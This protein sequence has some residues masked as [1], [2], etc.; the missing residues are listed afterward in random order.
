MQ[1]DFLNTY[2]PNTL[3]LSNSDVRQVRQQLSNYTELA[4]PDIANNPGTVIGDLI[5]TPQSYII[6]ALQKGMENAFSDLQLEN[7]ANGI[8]YNCDFTKSYIKNFG[9]D[10][11]LYY[12]SSGVLRL[13][14]SEDKDYEL[15]RST[16]FKLGNDIYSIYLPNTGN[17]TCLSTS[18]TPKDGENSSTIKDT[19]SGLWFCDVPVIGKNEQVT[20]AA[21]SQA[22]ISQI[23]PELASVYA[24][25]DFS[26]GVLA[27][28]VQ[29][30]AKKTQTTMFSA[31]LNTRYG[32]IQYLNTVCPFVESA[33]ALRDGDKELLRTYRNS[34]G[35]ASGCLDIFAR[36][37]S[38]E[39]TEVQQ[40]KLYLSEDGQWLE[41][42]W[43]YTGQ[44]Y[45]LESITHPSIDVKDLEDREIIS[46]SDPSLNL[47]AIA[48]Y[49]K[50]EKLTIRLKNLFD[51]SQNSLFSFNIETQGENKGKQYTYVTVT[52]Q[53]DPLFRALASTVEN[54]DYAPINSNV[55]VRGFTPV[56]IS[57]FDVVYT[58]KPGVIPDLD[59]A[60]D[61]IKIY[62]G[63]LG[64]P[65]QFSMAEIASIMG[66]VG[67]NYVKTV[68]VNAKVQWSI[69]DKIQNFQGEIEDTLETI[70]RSA[71]ELRVY[72]PNQDRTL[73]SQSMYACSP[74][75]IR[76]YVLENSIKFK[77][78][79]DV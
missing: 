37:Q 76:Y 7:V 3:E 78:V 18:S 72:Y 25:V 34:Y 38:Y 75:T 35:I 74:N 32:A 53:T 28:S 45:H 60:K 24:L 2:V 40:V 5:V 17:F 63:S 62:L 67:V 65:N 57:Q 77:E 11:S 10:T 71:D 19:G 56:I 29:N 8:V 14:L 79:R 46:S 70:I 39:F 50:H 33:Y 64:S 61:K 22:L 16:Q 47:G 31:S 69:G 6:T 30:L 68:D 54:I 23:I 36:T 43:N 21:G 42:E 55:L 48:A 12:P 49:T 73:T 44:P 1:I 15:D 9:V 27:D 59:T 66:E 51:S 52:Y 4:F 41:G 20:I 58:K 13:I 26:S